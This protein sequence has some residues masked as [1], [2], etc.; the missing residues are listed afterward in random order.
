MVC[1]YNGLT[2]CVSFIWCVA[3]LFSLKSSEDP[4]AY[5][6]ESISHWTQCQLLFTAGANSACWKTF[7]CLC[8]SFEEASVLVQR[9]QTMKDGEMGTLWFIND[10]CSRLANI[11]RLVLFISFSYGLNLTGLFLEARI[12][13]FQFFPNVSAGITVKIEPVWIFSGGH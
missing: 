7:S 1:L 11:Q 8:S 12:V 3:D 6:M 9:H 2:S 10:W 4:T 5:L 13:S